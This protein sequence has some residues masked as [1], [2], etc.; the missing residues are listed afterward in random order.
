MTQV[1]CLEITTVASCSVRCAICPQDVLKA[2][3]PKEGPHRLSMYDYLR[4]LNNVPTHVRIHFSGLV[5]PWL[6]PDCTLMLKWALHLGR[7]VALYTTL[8][9]MRSPDLVAESLRYF[10]HLVDVVCIHEADGTNMK[11]Q[12]VDADAFVALLDGVNVERMKMCGPGF[13]PI[14]RA[15]LVQIGRKSQHT[16]PIKCSYSDTYTHNVMLPNGDVYLCCM[17]YGLKH[18]IGNLF[19]ETWEQLNIGRTQIKAQNLGVEAGETICRKCH[20]AVAA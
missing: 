4:A 18:K 1:D 2:A 16:G 15:G 10:R 13:E 11:P 9:G 6:N 20:G 3:Y 8:V 19:T 12:D 14:D 7:R 5:E 17:D